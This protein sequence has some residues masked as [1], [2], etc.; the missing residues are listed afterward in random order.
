M[1]PS[2][3]ILGFASGILGSVSLIPQIHKSYTTKS[4]NDI[5]TKTICLMYC[6]LIIAV[7]YGIL[8][9]HA[10]IYAMNGIACSLYVILHVIKIRNDHLHKSLQSEYSELERVTVSES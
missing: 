4:S 3:E 2:P 1:S 5:S 7:I 9:K 10:A 8:I 6:A